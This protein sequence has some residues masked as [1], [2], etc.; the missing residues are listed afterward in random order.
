[1]EKTDRPRY[2]T[3]RDGEAAHEQIRADDDG[4]GSGLMAIDDPHT[5]TI[6]YAPVTEAAL[7][8]AHERQPESHE[9]SADEE[10]G[11][12]SPSVNVNDGRYRESNIEDVLDRIGDEISTGTGKT[13]PLEDIN[14]VVP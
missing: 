1:M 5:R 9:K 13:C 4:L 3:H 7:K 14:N 10:H 8:T 2:R 12:T 6:N 11:A